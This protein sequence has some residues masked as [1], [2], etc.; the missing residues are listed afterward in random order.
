MYC[1]IQISSGVSNRTLSEPMFKFVGNMHGD[2]A[3]GRQG[4]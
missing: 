3:L 4:I 1:L 2:E